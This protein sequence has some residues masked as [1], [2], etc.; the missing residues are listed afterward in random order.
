[1]LV[2]LLQFHPELYN[3]QWPNQEH[4]HG[5]PLHMY[6]EKHRIT[7]CKF[8]VIKWNQNVKWNTAELSYLT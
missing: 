6:V 4:I 1:M 3:Y 2:D 7:E 5:I 8:G